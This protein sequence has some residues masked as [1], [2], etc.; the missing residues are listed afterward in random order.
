[1]REKSRY[2]TASVHPPSAGGELCLLCSEV[3]SVY[4][5]L[6]RGVGLAIPFTGSV[7]LLQT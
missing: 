1:M 6:E 2:L 5:Q 3:C 7:S 4:V